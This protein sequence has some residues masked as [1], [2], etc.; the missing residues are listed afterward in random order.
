MRDV[1]ILGSTG[2]IGRQALEVVAAHSDDFRVVGLSGWSNEELL[3]EQCRRFGPK[4]V[5]IS[6]RARSS[7][8][9]ELSGIVP[10]VFTGS[11]GLLDLACMNADVVLVA[12]TGIAGM[13]PTLAA[14]RHGATIALAN[15]E[16]VVAAGDLLKQALSAGRSSLIPVDSEH[17]AVF[18]CL[19]SGRH[20][21]VARIILTASGGPFL[22]KTRAD[23]E[24]VTVSQALAHP[25]WNMGKKVTVDSATLMNKGLEVIEAH[26]LFEVPYDR[27][28]VTIHPQSIIHSM[29]EFIDGSVVAQMGIPDMRVPIQYAL[30]YPERI[31]GIAPRY[32]PWERGP[33]TF[34]KPDTTTFP[35]L[36]LAYEA[37]RRGGLV[38]AA[39]SAANE[40]AVE[41]FLNGRLRFLDIARLVESVVMKAPSNLARDIKDIMEVDAWARR[42]AR[43][44]I[45][46]M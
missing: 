39:M 32:V 2:S 26:H 19:K 28:D 42:V 8:L 15:K 31:K 17:S 18:Q 29:V 41:E 1:I 23:L 20:S 14:L 43:S 5:C 38:P 12:I 24:R 44:T 40:V 27:I 11:S 13:E 36:A 9:Q 4:A 16:T 33:L 30:S 35:L 6:E 45:L 37:G 25:N 21:E 34:S 7:T 10:Q 3:I 22:G 46:A